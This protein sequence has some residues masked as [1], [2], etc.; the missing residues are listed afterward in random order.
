MINNN[1]LYN[2]SILSQK[3][4]KTPDIGSFR[5]GMH[6]FGWKYVYSFEIEWTNERVCRELRCWILSLVMLGELLIARGFSTLNPFYAY[7]YHDYHQYI[8]SGKVTATHH[9]CFMKWCIH[10]FAS[11]SNIQ[12]ILFIHQYGETN[13]TKMKWKLTNKCPSHIGYTHIYI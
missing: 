12:I 8:N 11:R 1:S 4:F 9:T 10:I 13:I 6:L 5:S 7:N 3:M 2:F